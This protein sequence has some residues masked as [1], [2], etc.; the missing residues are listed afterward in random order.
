[1]QN[2]LLHAPIQDFGDINFVLRRARDLVN[3][4]ELLQLVAHASEHADHFA[5]QRQLVNAARISVGAVEILRRAR[6]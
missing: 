5:V 6:A 2:Q 3:P 4:A 1:M